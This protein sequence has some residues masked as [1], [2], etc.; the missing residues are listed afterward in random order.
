M[1]VLVPLI[2]VLTAA[3]LWTRYC[4]FRLLTFAITG[5]V[6]V[7]G[8]TFTAWYLTKSQH[9]WFCIGNRLRS[10]YDRIRFRVLVKL[11]NW[12]CRLYCYLWIIFVALG[13]WI[14][15]YSYWLNDFL[16][17]AGQLAWWYTH[18][19]NYLLWLHT[20]IDIPDLQADQ[21]WLLGAATQ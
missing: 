3:A 17:F 21:L 16:V 12:Y 20:D 15:H 4:Q 13:I 14:D 11:I 19:W 6:G 10:R 8:L 7:F 18:S 1:S 5:I 9:H 2:I